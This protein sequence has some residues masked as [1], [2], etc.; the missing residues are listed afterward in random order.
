MY[1]D[2][3][4]C[5][6]MIRAALLGGSPACVTAARHHGL[7]VLTASEP[8][9]IRL[10]PHGHRHGTADVDHWDHDARDAFG[11]P[12]VTQTLRQILRC[13]GVEDFVVALESALHQKKIRPADLAWLEENTNKQAREAIAFARH[14]AESGLETLVRWRLRGWGIDVR[15]QQD[16]VSVGRVDLVIGERLIVEVD[17]VENHAG[18]DHRHRDLVRDAHAAAWGFVTLRFD[19]AM[20]VHDWPTVKLA[21]RAHVDRGLHLANP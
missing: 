17:G 5:E 6:P 7:W 20:V 3:D 21:I 9:H 12:P 11:L 18:A 8:L 16:I 2:A 14:D 10:R 19:Y 1:A 13:R 15:T 4:T